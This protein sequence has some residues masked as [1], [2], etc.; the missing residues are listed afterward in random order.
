MAGIETSE[1][2]QT[3]GRGGRSSL[4]GNATDKALNLLEA[5]SAP[6]YPHR[7]G[8]I[9]TAAGVPKASAHRIVNYLVTAG[10]LASDGSGGYG[11]GP[12]IRALAARITQGCEEDQV[13]RAELEVLG[14]RI[15]HT[16]HMGV[17]T[18]DAVT[19]LVK[20]SGP[21]AVQDSSRVGQQLALHTTAIGKCV[22]A[23]L[24]DGELTAL[25]AR[26][27]LPPRTE[28]SLTDLAELRAELAKVRARGF[29]LDDEENEPGVRC[30]AV[31]VR[32][33]KGTVVGAVNVSTIA[34]L[35]SR[36]ALVGWADTVRTTAEALHGLLG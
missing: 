26:L 12:R 31:P 13:M 25:V 9:A 30:L 27:G 15:G 16:V 33:A 19:L 29:A 36:E 2:S 14:R 6:G 3:T 4:A 17:R 35:E 7:L 24:A 10:F 23:G 11:P 34:F 22:L 18:G 32:N 28:N 5:A 21:N 20:V 8:D 1:D